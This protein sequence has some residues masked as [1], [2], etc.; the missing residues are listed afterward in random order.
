MKPFVLLVL[1]LVACEPETSV[2][3]ICT[4]DVVCEGHE[5]PLTMPTWCDGDGDEYDA[6]WLA[7]SYCYEAMSV[8]CM[9]SAWTCDCACEAVPVLARE[10]Y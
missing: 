1:F 4:C 8:A 7:M 2:H 5:A 6:G 10:C 3:W 9:D